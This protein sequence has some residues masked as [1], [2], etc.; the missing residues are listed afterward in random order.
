MDLEPNEVAKLLNLKSPA[1]VAKWQTAGLLPAHRDASGALW[2]PEDYIKALAWWADG[3]T[4]TRPMLRLFRRLYE[5]L[6]PPTGQFRLVRR[7]QASQQLGIPWWTLV[8]RAEGAYAPYIK[9]LSGERFYD[10][11]GIEQWHRNEESDQESLEET[12]LEL[13]RKQLDQSDTYVSLEQAAA[14]IGVSQPT[15]IEYEQASVVLFTASTSGS[16]FPR[17]Y[18]GSLKGFQ[19]RY[20][21]YTS[22][23]LCRLHLIEYAYARA[24]SHTR[25]TIGALCKQWVKREHILTPP[26]ASAILGLWIDWWIQNDLFPHIKIGL[27]HYLEPDLT[28]QMAVLTHMPGSKEAASYLGIP[29]KQ[30]F[31]FVTSSGLSLQHDAGGQRRYSQANLDALAK[32]LKAKREVRATK[33]R[34]DERAKQPEYCIERIYELALASLGSNEPVM[35]R[36]EIQA[37]LG[38]SIDQLKSL[39]KAKLILRISVDKRAQNAYSGAFAES[40]KSFLGQ[41]PPAQELCL[42]HLIQYV[43]G[44]IHEPDKRLLRQLCQ[45]LHQAGALVKPQEAREL[46]G[47]SPA[48]FKSWM[49]RDF[50]M[51]LRL[52]RSTVYFPPRYIGKQGKILALRNTEA[53]ATYIGISPEE[54]RTYSKTGRIDFILDA[55]GYKHFTDDSLKDLK[56]R[57]SDGYHA[58]SQDAA[59]RL[60][61]SARTVI[62]YYHRGLLQG[63]RP[64]KRAVTF[65]ESEIKRAERELSEYT[66]CKGFEWLEAFLAQ[67]K[68]GPTFIGSKQVVRLLRGSPDLLTLGK[69]KRAGIVPFYVQKFFANYPYPPAIFYPKIY[70]LR[71]RTFVGARGLTLELA[72]E[73]RDHC[74]ECG[75]LPLA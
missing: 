2:H 75:R 45:N 42:L 41:E 65:P 13:A 57:I 6:G 47:L 74:A 9:T 59:D 10:V 17:H 29:V 60:G 35:S 3:Q 16:K 7:D 1:T 18:L 58:G 25:K 21:R 44:V 70:F 23:A 11:A 15:L 51:K 24:H 34:L 46:L 36:C 30:F 68:L 26:Q 73:F 43:W 49:A 12:I 54:M 69:W 53:A 28:A 37:L 40:L 19:D 52:S 61:L 39:R 55:A 22:A 14:I 33:V 63:H 66:V 5:L 64:N 72:T 27:F 8:D 32:K 31:N 50:L 48:R 20:S 62:Q 71:L 56:R 4:V 67:S 38:L